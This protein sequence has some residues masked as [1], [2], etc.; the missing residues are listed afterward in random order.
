[1]QQASRT[2][3]ILGLGNPLSGDDIFGPKAL[4][5]LRQSEPKLPPSITLID[6][7][8]DLLNHIE[9]F[10]KYDS[11]LLIDAILD[12]EGKL[13]EPGKVVVLDESKLQSLPETSSS[14]HQMSPLLAVKLFRTLH[15]EAQQTQI[16]LVGLIVDQLTSEPRYA[17]ADR[18]AEAA[19][20]V[21][22]I[23]KNQS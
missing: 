13:G 10:T 1:L 5:Q 19:A 4:E 16:T 6:A 15:P 17:I 8:T 2:T 9:D 21:K 12:P 3:L 11:V 22:T 18:I 23:F 14:I 20:V 7:H